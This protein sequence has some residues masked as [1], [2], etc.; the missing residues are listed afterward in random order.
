M[1]RDSHKIDFTTFGDNYSLE[2]HS[3][4]YT[5]I[6]GKT[7]YKKTVSL[8]A[9]PN[10]NAKSI[11]HNIS[12]FSTMLNLYGYAFRSS[13]Q[14]FFVL[15]NTSNPSISSSTAINLTVN[16]TTIVVTTGTDRSNMVGYVTLYYTKTTG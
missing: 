11:A 13:D 1:S 2:E 16:A 15:P 9:L 10:N 3:T 8:G 5:W 6:D 12:N 14:T 4:G 7:I